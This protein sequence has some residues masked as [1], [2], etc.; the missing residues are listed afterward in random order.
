MKKKILSIIALVLIFTLSFG[1]ISLAADI[2]IDDTIMTYNFCQDLR[3]GTYWV[4][5][6]TGYIFYEDYGAPTYSGVVYIKTINGGISW[7]SPVAITGYDPDPIYSH[8]SSW[9]EWNTP[10]DSG[11]KVHFSILNTKDAKLDY[12]Y[13]DTYDDTASSTIT[14]SSLNAMPAMF[15]MED[16]MVSITK[17]RGGTLA[18]SW[19]GDG[20]ATDNYGFDTSV[21]GGNTWITKD[22]PWE[23]SF[24][25]MEIYPSNLSDPDDLWGVFWDIS[26]DELSLKT[27]DDSSDSWSEQLISATM[28]DDTDL[29]INMSADIRHSDKDI[30]LTAWNKFSA[31]NTTLKVWDIANSGNITSLT[32]IITSG[33]GYFQNA[34]FI[35]QTNNDIYV[36]YLKGTIESSVA[37]YYQKSIDGGITWSGEISF[38]DASGDFR[39]VW[40]SGIKESL[41]GKFMPIFQEE[42]G[43]TSDDLETNY[44]HSI[45]ITANEF[46]NPAIA[47]EYVIDCPTC[48]D[49]LTSSGNFTSNE[50]FSGGPPGFAVIDKAAESSGAPPIWLWGWVGMFSIMVPGFFITYM[51]RKYGACLLYTSPSP[52][53]RS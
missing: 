11:T 20:V 53:D 49:N 33:D 3:I 5:N 24:D 13:F 40:T 6:T 32:D 22:S 37:V 46:S 1:T 18:I 39:N 21:D 2:L 50:T 7:S 23:A 25:H 45:T 48:T 52:R 19:R 17:T 10:G 4:S 31:T 15:D 27:Y 8:R 42:N 28:A 43:A 36:S 30:I 51:E 14:V 9:A 12:F 35:D 47:P 26:A 34:T 16:F 38:S 29:Y 41:G 44:I